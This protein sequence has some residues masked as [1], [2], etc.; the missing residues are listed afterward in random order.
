M[1]DLKTTGYPVKG[2]AWLGGRKLGIVVNAEQPQFSELKRINNEIQG[3][4]S[5]KTDDHALSKNIKDHGF[6][7]KVDKIAELR[8]PPHPS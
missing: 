2:R 4:L 3:T 7:F 5:Q 1:M 8:W 6:L